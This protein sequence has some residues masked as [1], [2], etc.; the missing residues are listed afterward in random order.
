M[1]ARIHFV[2]G[3]YHDYIDLEGTLE[4]I[5]NQATIEICKRKPDDQWSEILEED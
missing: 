5:K 1:K 3:E 4:S 2:H